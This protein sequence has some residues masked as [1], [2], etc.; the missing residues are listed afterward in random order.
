MAD[1]TPQP[2]AGPVPAPIGV[3]I[4]QEFPKLARAPIVEAVITFAGRA[5]AEWTKEAMAQR[6]HDAM[7]GYPSAQ[8]MNHARVHF[9]LEFQQREMPTSGIAPSPKASAED[10]GWVGLRLVSADEKQVVTVTRDTLSISRLT[11]YEGWGAL[12]AEALRLWRI[13]RDLA[14]VD[15]IE[16]MQTRFINRLEV[17][18]PDFS[19]GEYFTGFGTQPAGMIA[20]PFLHQDALHFPALASYQI[21]LV[22]TFDAQAMLVGTPQAIPLIVLLEALNPEPIPSDD[23]TIE[24]RLAEM[25]WLKNYAFFHSVTKKFLD[26]CR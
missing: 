22:R 2:S 13:H 14:G 15:S 7:S 10:F 26:L 11:P 20:G 24:R 3:D 12:C 5:R 1:P 9:N 21:N 25:H 4:H 8:H 17:P 19:P 16:Q 18:V 6:I 23:A